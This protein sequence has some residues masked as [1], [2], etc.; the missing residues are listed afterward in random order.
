MSYKVILPH[1]VPFKRVPFNFTSDEGFGHHR[2]QCLEVPR[3]LQTNSEME[4]GKL[5][6]QLHLGVP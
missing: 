3:R 1:L 5:D 2:G 6:D 4:M